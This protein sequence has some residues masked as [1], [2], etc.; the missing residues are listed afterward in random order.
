MTQNENSWGSWLSIIHISN[1]K[2]YFMSNSTV[3]FYFIF[4]KQSFLSRF[5]F[6]PLLVPA[7]SHHLTPH[8]LLIECETSYGESTRSVSSLEA[9]PRSSSLYL[10]WAMYPTIGTELQTA[11]SGTRDKYWFH[12]LWPHNCPSH[13]TVIHIHRAYFSLMQVPQLPVLSHWG[14]TS[15]GQL[16]LWLSPPQYWPLCSHYHSILSMTGLQELGPVLRCRSLHQL[17]S[18]IV[19][20]FY[21]GN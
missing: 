3:F 10:G 6:P 13:T 8:P 19:W 18:V 11:S 20:R 7:T 2:L 12:D 16:F 14:I 9:G 15:S 5:P 17:P 4:L 1:L 21:G